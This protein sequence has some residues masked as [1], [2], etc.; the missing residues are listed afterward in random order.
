[1]IAV[2][3]VA[4][5]LIFAGCTS[6]TSSQGVCAA[7]AP[8]VE[9]QPVRA[10]SGETFQISGENFASRST[11]PDSGSEAGESPQGLPER[12]IS[13]EFVQHG[14]VWDLG[15]VDSDEDLSFK[16]DL[17]VPKDAKPGK[18]TVRATNA[19]YGPSKARFLVLAG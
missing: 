15:T 6:S 19:N 2:P 7:P 18:A 16:E 14:R 3:I 1:M 17:E 5:S 10:A 4:L 11:C 12:G 9:T 13:L 8:T